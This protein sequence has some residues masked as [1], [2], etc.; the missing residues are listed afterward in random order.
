LLIV[1]SAGTSGVHSSPEITPRA[2]LWSRHKSFFVIASADLRPLI[3]T[4]KLLLAP[5]QSG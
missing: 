4:G 5:H 1:R 3:A 2:A